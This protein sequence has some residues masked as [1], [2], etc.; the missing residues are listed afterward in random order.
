[1]RGLAESGQANIA[2]VQSQAAYGETLSGL[3]GQKQAVEQQAVTQSQLIEQSVAAATTEANIQRATQQLQSD[4]QLFNEVQAIEDNKKAQVANLVQLSMSGE[5]TPQQLEQLAE[6]YGVSNE[7]L[8]TVLNASSY[9]DPTGDL[10]FRESWSFEEILKDASTGN[11]FVP[12]L[13]ALFGLVYGVSRQFVENVGKQITVSGGKGLEFTG[14]TPEL[15]SQINNYYA[16]FEGSDQISAGFDPSLTGQADSI[17]FK[18]R[19]QSYK[20]Y[21]EALKALKSSS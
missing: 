5:Y 18:Y 11:R 6:A 12:G 4:Q 17:V 16:G 14:T 8:T 21:N 20:S 2:E 19:G 10:T 1:M 7:E 9:Y 13:G 3:Y 15:I